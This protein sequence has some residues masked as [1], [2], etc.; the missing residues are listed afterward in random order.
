VNILKLVPFIILLA[1]I[2]IAAPPQ[3]S[4]VL[5]H[6]GVFT[7]GSLEGQSDERPL[8]TVQIDTFYMGSHEVTVFEYLRCARDN[9]CRMPSWWNRRFSD[10]TADDKTG[11]EWLDRPI[12]GVS[13]EDAVAYCNWV[14]NN[15]RLPTE[16]EW[17]YAARGTGHSKYAWGDDWD[18]AKYYAVVEKDLAPVQSKSPN[19]LGLYDLTG[20]AWE[21]C[22]DRYNSRYYTQSPTKNPTGPSDSAR[23][24]Y[25]TVRGGGWNTYRWNLRSAN[26]NYGE[27]FRRYEGV[28]FR[29]ARSFR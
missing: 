25:R 26:R 3:D 18:S 21:W 1:F 24:P 27:S 9:R 11:S 19:R 20:N 14:G 22:S 17:E 12:T 13:W 4:L 23:F 29:I 2:L 5:V 7:M 6:G 8:H 15:T 16:A 28:G 10:K